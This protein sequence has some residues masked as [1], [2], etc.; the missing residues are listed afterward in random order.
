MRFWGAVALRYVK[1]EVL[2]PIE[3][4]TANEW[5]NEPALSAR[6]GPQLFARIAVN[7]SP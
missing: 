3:R 2:T 7:H 4:M 5:A 1:S 6:S